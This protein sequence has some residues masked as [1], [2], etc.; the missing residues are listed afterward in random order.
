MDDMP[1]EIALDDVAVPVENLIGKE[2]EGMRQA[3]SWITSGR[4]YQ[5]CRG[6]GVAQRCLDLAVSYAR[7]R[8][9]FGAPLA[10]ARPCSS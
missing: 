6:L 2:G 9:T 7:Q 1:C 4:L 10:I 5:A 3:Q 8:V